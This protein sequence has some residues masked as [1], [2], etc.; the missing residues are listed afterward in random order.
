MARVGAGGTVGTG[1]VVSAVVEVLVAEEAPP[2]LLTVTLPRQLA[3]AVL[4]GR[5]LLTLVTERALPALP[6]SAKTRQNRP[7][8]PFLPLYVLRLP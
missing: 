5:V 8:N 2:A 1:L 4:A 7:F 6:A 3:G